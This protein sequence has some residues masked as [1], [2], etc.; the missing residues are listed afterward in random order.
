MKLELGCGARP[1]DGYL[2]HDRTYHDEWVDVAFDLE[3]LPWPMFDASCEQ[4]LATDVFEH[5]R[6]WK[7]QVSEW[8]DECWRLLIEGGTLSMRLPAWD[9]PLSFRDPTHHRMFHEHT[10]DYW[11][12][13]HGLHADFGRYY[14]DTGRWWS[15]RMVIREEGDFR[16]ILRKR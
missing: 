14:F 2:H 1:S 4:I 15:V 5:L 12:P 13:D 8:L 9:N 10:F 3:E 7:V 16:Y 6:P 11:D